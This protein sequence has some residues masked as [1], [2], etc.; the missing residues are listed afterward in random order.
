VLGVPGNQF[1]DR[2]V[3]GD[4]DPGPDLQGRAVG[5]QLP[6]DLLILPLRLLGAV[7]AE[8][9]TL[10]IDADAGL[11]GG[12]VQAVGGDALDSRHGD[13]SQGWRSMVLP[14]FYH[15]T[16]RAHVPRRRVGG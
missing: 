16:F 1:A 4:L 9:D 5:D 2:Q 10:A 13:A 7:R 12:L 8:I 3:G 6:D 11:T 15:Q 14:R